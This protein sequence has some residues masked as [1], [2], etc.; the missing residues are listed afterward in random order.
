MR[1]LLLIL[2][3]GCLSVTGCASTQTWLQSSVCDCEVDKK[4]CNIDES[5][6]AYAVALHQVDVAHYRAEFDGEQAGVHA[7]QAREEEE[8]EAD[9]EASYRSME[10]LALEPINPT[11][12]QS[13]ITLETEEAQQ[14]F[15]NTFGVA[16][17]SIGQAFQDAFRRHDRSVLAIHRPGEALELYRDGARLASR[18]LSDYAAVTPPEDLISLPTGAVELVRNG[19]VQLKLVHAREQEDGGITYYVAIYKLIGNKIGTIFHHPIASSSP[20]GEL[21]RQ[22]DLRYLHGK[23]H[24]IIEWITLD[25]EGMPDGEPQRFEWNRWEGVYRIPGPPPTAPRQPQS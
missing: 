9:E 21:T 7:Q 19:S 17:P 6:I 22:A 24:R 18:D 25:E 4:S 2:L 16:P 5:D 14:N 8:K 11:L 20:D 13:E 23:D 3:L 15:A 10:E 1:H 12:P